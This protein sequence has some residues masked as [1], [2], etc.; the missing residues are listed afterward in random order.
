MEIPKGIHTG[1]CGEE[2]LL[3]GNT[4]VS[5]SLGLAHVEGGTTAA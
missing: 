4:G 5:I 2:E 1:Y 3:E